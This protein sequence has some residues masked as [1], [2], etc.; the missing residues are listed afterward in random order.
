MSLQH[1]IHQELIAPGRPDAELLRRVHT[2][3]DSYLT[4]HNKIIDPTTGEPQFQNLVSCP[5][6]WL[7]GLWEQING[8]LEN[9]S[10][11]SLN[12]FYR[13]GRQRSTTGWLGP[14]G[15]P[16]CRPDRRAES[17]RYLNACWADLDHHKLGLTVGQAV[18]LVID[19][20][21]NGTVP[22]PTLTIQSGR[23]LWAVW[24][25]ES[26]R[27][28]PEVIAWWNRLQNKLSDHH[29]HLAAD[30]GAIDAARIC[31]IP[32]STNTR[33]KKR[34]SFTLLGDARRYRIEEIANWLGVQKQTYRR[35]NNSLIRTSHQSRGALGQ[36]ARWKILEDT[37]WTFIEQI[38]GGIRRGHR[39]HALHLLGLIINR[40]YP[41][42]HRQAACTNGL[43]RLQNKVEGWDDKRVL[44]EIL[45]A[46]NT[47]NRGRVT[48]ATIANWLAITAAE[49]QALEGLMQ[50]PSWP[51]AGARVV[52]GPPPAKLAKSLRRD[53]LLS[54]VDIDAPPPL[55]AIA[56]RMAAEGLQ[57]VPNTIRRDLA[58]LRAERLR[59]AGQS[60]KS[61][62]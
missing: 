51:A 17:L 57:A 12:G 3:A 6:G 55:R 60:P 41:L 22:M 13:P 61:P 11:F 47:H 19:L 58:E 54:N 49:S 31:R 24:L 2:Q 46:A 4:L 1:D 53:W 62:G 14:D 44:A 43:M 35:K 8:E 37:F 29:K 7:P 40:K 50:R 20:A 48:Y 36:L 32:G 28:W 42:H 9:D 30:Q 23:G 45:A 5:V 26:V 59:R 52:S 21:A 34:V 39:H 15:E 33:A 27:A 16:L 56:T 10:Y 25:I 18:G 38:R